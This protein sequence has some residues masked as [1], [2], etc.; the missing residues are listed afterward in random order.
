MEA[1]LLHNSA[2]ENRPTALSKSEGIC[3]NKLER[4]LFLNNERNNKNGKSSD[5]NSMILQAFRLVRVSGI[6]SQQAGCPTE[7]HAGNLRK[8]PSS[9]LGLDFL[10]R[11]SIFVI[12]DHDGRY[13]RV[14]VSSTLQTCIELLS[15]SHGIVRTSWDQ[16]LLGPIPAPVH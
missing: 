8:I 5:V 16:V 13:S 3:C 6:Y 15:C 7:N 12:K 14:A 10:P 9:G 11:I 4:N 2:G 1:D